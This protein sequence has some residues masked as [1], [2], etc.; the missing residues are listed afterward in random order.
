MTPSSQ[1]A[2]WRAAAAA[3]SGQTSG[4]FIY[5]LFERTIRE[6]GIAGHLLGFGAGTGELARRMQGIGKLE[7]VTC[8][9][10]MRPAGLAETGLRWDIADLN[11]KTPYEDQCFNV[12]VSSE[13]IEHLEN[14]RAIV[15]EWFRLLKPGGWLFFSTPNNESLRSIL[16]LAF[17]GHYQAF[18]DDSY[19]AHITALLHKDMERIVMEAGFELKGFR[20]T[21]YGT[22][23]KLRRVSWQMLSVGLLSGKRFSD[24]V[25]TVCRRPL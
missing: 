20:Y 19:P 15:R 7:S 18:G 21:N 14:P 5:R 1:I 6:F 23:P 17:R 10:L 9:D 11:D 4:D 22:I 8:I 2:D 25:L 3:A 16:A 13:V 12:I 24:N